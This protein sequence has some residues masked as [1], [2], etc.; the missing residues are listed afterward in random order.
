MRVSSQNNVFSNPNESLATSCQITEGIQRLPAPTVMIPD[1]F[2]R[3]LLQGML[4]AD[5]ATPPH[6]LMQ[7]FNRELNNLKN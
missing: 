7:V 3:G 5:A 6:D 4:S 1:E 2:I